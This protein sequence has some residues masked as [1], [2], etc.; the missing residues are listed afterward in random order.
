MFSMAGTI[1][2]D[3]TGDRAREHAHVPWIWPA[4]T[5]RLLA[6]TVIAAALLLAAQGGGANP[7]PAAAPILRVDLN[8]APPQVLS[9]LPHVGPALLRHV[10]LAREARPLDS[11]ED[12]RRRVRGLGASTIAGLAPH[13][14]F[15]STAGPFIND[16]RNSTGERPDTGP[17]AARRK[18]TR[19]RKSIPASPHPRLV[20]RSSGADALSEKSIAHHE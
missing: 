13:L 20:A 12:A 11:L 15:D 7:G 18:T 14:R 2:V 1:S 5:R 16:S 4:G 17:Q 9:A 19:L 6:G 10:V 8:T 3:E